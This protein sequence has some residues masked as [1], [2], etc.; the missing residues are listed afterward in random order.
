L[1]CIALLSAAGYSLVHDGCTIFAASCQCVLEAHA[2][3]MLL[4]L[5]F[6]LQGF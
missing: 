5:A 1:C 4:L 3:T 2:C 6:V